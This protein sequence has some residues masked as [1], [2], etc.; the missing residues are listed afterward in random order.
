MSLKLIHGPP[1]S[2]RAGLVRRRFAEELPRSPLLVVPTL[3]DV[4]AFERE[5]TRDGEALLGGAVVSFDGLFRAV[6]SAT[7]VTSGGWV[8]ATQRRR[9]VAAAARRARLRVLARSAERPGFASA[10]AELVAELGAAMLDPDSVE[11][12]ASG[13]ED[14]AYLCELASIYRAYLE[15]RG[16]LGLAD[17]H[18]LAAAAIAALRS[19]PDRWGARPVFLYGFDDLTREQLELVIALSRAGPVTVA[20]TYEDRVALAA[21]ATL[22]QQLREIGPDEEVAVAADPANT[23]SPLLYAIERGFAVAEPERAAPDGSLVLLRSA[24]ERAEAEAIG[25]EV[26][27]LIAGGTAPGEIAVALR[28]PAARGGLI[29]RVLASY[30]VPAALE[31]D[32]PVSGT[33]TGGALLALLAAAFTTRRSTD[34]LR[35][36]RGPRRGWPPHADRLERKVLRGR[37]AGAGEAAEAWREISGKEVGE[38]GRLREASGNP[39]R[40]LGVVS[41]IARDIAEWPLATEA[42][43]GSV[44]RPA[45]AEEL[46][47]GAK[48]AAALAELAEL[49]GLEPGPEELIEAIGGLRMRLWRG[50]AEGRVRIASPYQLRAGRFAH[51]FV[52]SLQDGEFPR[53]GSASPFLSDEQRAGIGLP[54]RAGADV[55]E[56]YLF[57]VCLTLPTRGLWLSCRVSDESGGSEEPSPLIG[58]VRRVLDPPPPEDPE[59][60]DPLEAS[61][62]RG[63]GLGEVVFAPG[64]TPSEDELARSLAALGEADREEALGRLELPAGVPE[65]V[66]PRLRAAADREART[67]A[68]G[69]L[70]VPEVIAELASRRE[71]AGTTLESFAGCS[72]RWFVERELRPAPLGPDPESMEQGSLMHAALE[73]LYRE[74]P[75]AEPV[76]RRSSLAAWKRRAREVLGAA[77]AE[78]GISGSTPVERAMRRR[79][80]RLLDAFLAREADR[81]PVRLAPLLL[82]A[83]FGSGEKERPALDLG[84]WALRGRI[85]RVDCDASEASGLVQ[86][87]KV[88][89]SATPAA[90]FGEQG[91]LQ[92]PLY[93]LAL[94]DLWG[95][96]PLGGL[97]HPLGASEPKPRGAVLA[98][99]AEL[100]DGYPLVSTD[101]LDEEAFATCLKEARETSSG[102]VARM[103]SGDITRDPLGEECPRW[104]G[105]APICRRERGA[106]ERLEEENGEEPAR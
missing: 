16:G 97:Y 2:G 53:R 22:L 61:L 91:K 41:E 60:P 84:D 1:N 50:P 85:D 26:A 94:R 106:S 3:D 73:A 39:A 29:A 38:L 55:E 80:E 65:R 47:A 37:L 21:R 79:V 62:V 30:G 34:L 44:P 23:E 5:L 77:A 31:A 13:L 103:R 78:R 19:D 36:L 15:I 82:E 9:L 6:A 57:Y 75:D 74:P 95:I 24:G 90:K 58:E 4:F 42:A 8:S 98:E 10:A 63:R 72:Y 89:G 102:A 54:E 17:R 52:A 59:N 81:D 70:S 18:T 35:Y 76:P 43:R 87:Y 56:R 96:E 7:G 25:A 48:I 12:A 92:L 88:S 104:C 20:L 64:E 14:S 32:V 68:P 93:M 46:R 83:E 69:P 67:R 99:A 105:F 86:D 66:G 49:R 45:E 71:Y 100:L 11:A 51:L 28:N 40:L 101:R 27:R 33:A